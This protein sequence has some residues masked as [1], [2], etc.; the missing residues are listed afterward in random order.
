VSRI[1]PIFFVLSESQQPINN[2]TSVEMSFRFSFKAD[3]D[4]ESPESNEETNNA[5][6]LGLTAANPET[7]EVEARELVLE[8]VSSSLLQPPNSPKVR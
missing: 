1:N 8:D 6:D 3:S 2:Y 4:D 7:V 5:G